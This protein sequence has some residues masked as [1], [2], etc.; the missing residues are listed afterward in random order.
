[1][2]VEGSDF[3]VAA[4][5]DMLIDH[6]LAGDPAWLMEPASGEMVHIQPIDAIIQ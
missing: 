2:P 5:L 1:V 4:D 3:A 6:V